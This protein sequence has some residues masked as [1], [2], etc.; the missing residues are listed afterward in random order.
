M[1]NSIGKIN[2]FVVLM[3]EN[4]SFDHMLGFM[5]SPSYP[6]EGLTGQES[7]PTT[8]QPGGSR[9]TVTADAHASGDL[10]VDPD[11]DVDHVNVQLFGNPKGPDPQS[12]DRNQGF[13]V[14]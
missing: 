6:I 2:H 11:H 7:N 5:K 1:A 9:L 10:H 12:P 13:I 8:F 14:D 3:M 4:R